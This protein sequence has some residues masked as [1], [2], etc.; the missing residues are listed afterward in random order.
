MTTALLWAFAFLWKGIVQP[1]FESQVYRG[2]DVAGTWLLDNPVNATTQKK[3]FDDDESMA[4]NQHAHS[5]RG[6]LTFSTDG[7][8]PVAQDLT[9]EIR[10]RLVCFTTRT[11]SR[12]SVGYTCVLAE[13]TADGKRMI[14]HSVYY[15]LDESKVD[16]HEVTY[17]RRT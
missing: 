15:D 11:A 7:A 4:L 10:D 9:G 12:K 13:V 3:Q 17:V 1:W 8:A 6:T 5:L 2:L 16:S 14:G